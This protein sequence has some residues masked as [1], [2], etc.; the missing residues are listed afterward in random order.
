MEKR[1]KKRNKKKLAAAGTAVVTAGALVVGG[2]FGE[3]AEFLE[4][5]AA[6]GIVETDVMEEGSEEEGEERSSLRQRFRARILALPMVL[7]M[8]VILP[9]WGLGWGIMQLLP[10]VARPLGLGAAM[11]G[12]AA[13]GAKLLCPELP[14]K[15][16]FSRRSLGLALLAAGL[17][18]A[19][20]ALLPLVWEEYEPAA[21]LFSA[22][23]TLGGGIFLLWPHAG[24]AKETERAETMEEA[25]RRV[26]EAADAAARH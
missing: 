8:T 20:N 18:Y 5:D 11:L 2:L 10:L 15:K 21:Q 7:R 4:E 3:P 9:L 22:L 14:L 13:A 16:F 1:T 19:A 6:E 24:K 26:L 12:A 17:L 25:R 23:L